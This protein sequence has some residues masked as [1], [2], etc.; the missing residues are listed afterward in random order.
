MPE[1][2]NWQTRQIPKSGPSQGVRVQ[3]PSLAFNSITCRLQDRHGRTKFVH[4]TQKLLNLPRMPFSR[5]PCLA[6]P[7]AITNP[8][9]TESLLSYLRINR[10]ACFL[11][12]I[13]VDTFVLPE[14]RYHR[15]L[16]LCN[17]DGL[18]AVSMTTPQPLQRPF[19][20]G[21]YPLPAPTLKFLRRNLNLRRLIGAKRRT[22]SSP[23]S[24]SS[25]FLPGSNNS[26]PPPKPK[27]R[28]YTGSLFISLKG[29]FSRGRHIK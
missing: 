2:W 28:P 23:R 16:I 4:A 3:V 11:F 24:D 27:A 22:R 5:L 17:C 13:C 6:R 14:L 10:V 15:R 9:I 8:A 1:W 18:P 21:V 7:L 29:L 12:G 25:I 20:Q 19:W 26:S